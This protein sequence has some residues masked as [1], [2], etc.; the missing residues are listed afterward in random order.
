MIIASCLVG[1]DEAPFACVGRGLAFPERCLPG[2]ISPERFQMTG[3]RVIVQMAYYCIQST[4]ALFRWQPV[5]VCAVLAYRYPRY[6]VTQNQLGS[7]S[8]YLPWTGQRKNNAVAPGAVRCIGHH[9]VL[10]IDSFGAKLDAAREFH[11]RDLLE[12]HRSDKGTRPTGVVL[13]PM[14]RRTRLDRDDSG[15][16]RPRATQADKIFP[17][18]P[19]AAWRPRNNHAESPECEI[20]SL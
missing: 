11:D 2:P 3:Q 8:A 12:L 9:A 13:T 10:Q 1:V 20:A 6:L 14:F 18:T 7:R 5:P 4:A 19:P 15:V 16:V 17:E